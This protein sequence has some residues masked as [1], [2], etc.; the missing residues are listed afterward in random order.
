[1]AEYYIFLHKGERLPEGQEVELKVTDTETQET[2]EVRARVAADPDQLPGADKLWLYDF[3][4]VGSR[5]LLEP[6][7]WALQIM[8]RLEE[9]EEEVPRGPQQH[10]SL[11]RRKGHILETLIRERQGPEDKPQG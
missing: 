9:E 1:M 3:D 10:I 5:D 7:P 4:G 2:L 6:K 8:E 11:G